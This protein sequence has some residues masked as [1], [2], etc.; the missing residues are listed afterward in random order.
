M[1]GRIAA[2][3]L[4][5]G[6]SRRF[7]RGSKLMADLRGRPVVDYAAA[8]IEAAGVVPRVAVVRPGDEDV[9]A[10]ARSRGFEVIEN[11][12]ASEGMGTSIAAGAIWAQA[13]DV[14]GVMICLGDAP[15]VTPQTLRR[16][17]DT[18]T[19]LQGAATVAARD[20]GRWRSPAVFARK[21]FKALAALTG[22]GGGRSI[23]PTA[24]RSAVVEV[25]CATPGELDDVDTPEALADARQRLGGAP[26]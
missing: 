16:L 26:S 7:G 2:V 1:S 9:R 3:L 21:H 12:R 24:G 6:S 5:A 18:F 8:A 25:S 14:D 11:P 15:F 13:A 22:D 4:A 19:S 23:F 17:V 10:A 20:E